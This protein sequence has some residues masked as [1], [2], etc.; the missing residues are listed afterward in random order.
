MLKVSII[1]DTCIFQLLE[2]IKTSKPGS[3][4]TVFKEYTE[5]HAVC[6]VLTLKKYLAQTKLLRKDEKQL[7]ISYQKPHKAIS[8]DTISHWHSI[9]NEQ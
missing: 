7:F 3:R 6:P 5:N 2:H 4:A 8:R 1:D 9:G